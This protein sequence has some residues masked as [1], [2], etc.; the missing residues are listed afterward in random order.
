MNWE[1]TTGAVTHYCYLTATEVVVGSHAGSGLTDN[2]GA[3]TPEEFLKGMY[4]HLV[5]SQLGEDI[6][7]QVLEAVVS[8]CDNPERVAQYRE[9]QAR[10]TQMD[11][12]PGASPPPGPTFSALRK[13]MDQYEHIREQWERHIPSY[14]SLAP[15]AETM[16]RCTALT[17]L[18]A[19]GEPLQ[20][21]RLAG[22][23]PNQDDGNGASPL[24][25]ALA[26]GGHRTLDT[27][28]AL[29]AAGA[30]PNRCDANGVYPLEV[31]I[32]KGL[33]EPFGL[34]K[35]A[36]VDTSQR[37]DG[38]KSYMHLAAARLQVYSP[39]LA[40]LKKLKL[41][42]DSQ[43]D[44]GRTALHHAAAGTGSASGLMK[45][46]ANPN[47]KDQDGETP[48]S[49]AAKEALSLRV[50][51]W[52]SEGHIGSTPVSY[53]IDNGVMTFRK[54]GR[55]RAI[56]IDSERNVA[57]RHCRQHYDYL[58][59]VARCVSMCA[60]ADLNLTTN[61]GVPI[62]QLLAN[63]GRPE[64]SDWACF[65]KVLKKRGIQLPEPR[66]E[67][68]VEKPIVPLGPKNA[69]AEAMLD[70]AE[71]GN[72]GLVQQILDAGVSATSAMNGWNLLH[73]AASAGSRKIVEMAIAG[74]CDVRQ[75][76]PNGFT[77]LHLVAG[78]AKDRA[79]NFQVTITRDGKQVTLTDR[80]EIRAAIGSHPDDAYFE[81]VELAKFFIEKGV[82][83]NAKT[84]KGEQPPLN[85][86]AALGPSEIVDILLETGRVEIDHQDSY[87]ST[88]LHMACRG[89]H[90]PS[91]Q[92]LLNAGAALDLQDKSGFTP[93][94]EAAVGNHGAIC[95][96]LVA[97]GADRQKKLTR[98]DKK[99]KV[100]MTAA[101]L[102]AVNGHQELSTMLQA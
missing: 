88:A 66:K 77:V 23:D 35:K 18:L 56:K 22:H 12:V 43:D 4:Q 57:H 87:G 8:T 48:L 2:A 85:H 98:E 37:F 31:A 41:D 27:I 20:P 70:A 99:F 61:E 97:A 32:A 52:F 93:L 100:G 14:A 45:L 72:H 25:V 83:V 33:K 51:R 89:G 69:T 13:T 40:Q 79:L 49:L 59:V 17:R 68:D 6:L 94:H 64:G 71:A 34:L 91:V 81:A 78:K 75:A 76:L 26:N 54:N 42:I 3:C 55:K 73:V 95:R 102:A 7:G 1:K 36:K 62:G 96:L 11:D 15:T 38:G 80:D 92:S 74:G 44:Q 5:R 10:V 46:K 39:V 67:M 50:S 86:A 19:S 29:L 21:D 82:D 16:A 101:D 53:T 63:L 9:E 60:T 30:D 84:A 28:Q 24:N 65:T 58:G 47:I 90:L